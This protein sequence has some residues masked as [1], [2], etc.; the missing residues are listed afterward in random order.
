MS[1]PTESQRGK[2]TLWMTG[3]G[4]LA[5][6][7]IIL[8]VNYLTSLTTARLDMTE[9]DLHSLTDGTRNILSRI[10]KPVTIKLYI[11]PE[12]DLPAGIMPAILEAENLV[13]LFASEAPDG[14][15]KY[16]K[17]VTEPDTD[18]A[19]NATLAGVTPRQSG[20]NQFLFFGIVLTCEDRT[21][22][23]PWAPSSI[24]RQDPNS[25]D[26]LPSMLE[27]DIAKSLTEV[28]SRKKTKVGWM[29][30]LKLAG[31]AG[32]PMGGR[33]EEPW[34]LYN[35]LKQRF[36][37]VE[38]KTDAD[39]ISQDLNVLLLVHPAGF[40]ELT[41][42]AIDQYIL[43]GGNVVAFVDPKCLSVPPSGQPQF[44]GMPPQGGTPDNSNLDKLISSWGFTYDATQVVADRGTMNPPYQNP[45]A[46]AIGEKYLEGDNPATA[47]L[48][49]LEMFLPGGFTGSA[50]GHLSSLVLAKTS[51]TA[52]VG[53]AANF[54]P[55]R[56]GQQPSFKMTDTKQRSLAVR[57]TGKFKTAF[58]GGK[59]NPPPP[60]PEGGG[61]GGFPP[62]GFGPQG[63]QGEKG[64]EAPPANPAPAAPAAAPTPAPV[65][66]TATTPPVSA[67]PPVTA[68]TPPVSAATPPI[69][70]EP[71]KTPEGAPTPAVPPAAP[72][73]PAAPEPAPLLPP[74]SNP[75]PSPIPA[76]PAPG[77]PA[78]TPS[79]HITEG[80]KEASVY[81]VADVDMLSNQFAAQQIM[82][83]YWMMKNSN[84]A[85]ALNLVD[86]A[87]GDTDLL[88]VRSRAGNYR[89]FDKINQIREDARASTQSEMD[90]LQESIN[91]KQEELNK[92]AGDES[93]SQKSL[94]LAEK[95]KKEEA[96]K[97][98]AQFNKR[99]RELEKEEKAKVDGTYTFIRIMN[100]LPIP[101]CI[102][103]IGLAVFFIRRVRTAA[104]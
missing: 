31:G 61:P 89:P 57:L 45:A 56:Q 18:R 80:E 29:S 69:T 43:K 36:D 87:A 13:N 76:T 15:I 100:F 17:E 70:I 9:R 47:D 40:S 62:G 99:K 5:V 85:F 49:S 71:V 60:K 53:M 30:P 67:T 97:E 103:I 92:M 96:R 50:P 104:S 28:M 19:D 6:L 32:N 52:G 16:R 21:A 25:G 65:P 78:A 86:T 83:G 63:G 1:T 14:K 42:W 48:A 79:N 51:E 27:Y 12:K 94:T 90:K 55:E 64:P 37:L 41:Q 77:T 54:L 72:A 8:A 101:L 35:E 82:Q 93:T 58:P 102:V 39:T 66:A 20:P 44:P 11:S 95:K 84:I 38:V 81:L 7:G 73:T 22:V 26:R 24:F 91:K 10:E 46:L 2:S 4:A 3:L 74:A 23:I 88:K 33:G 75:P 68:T 59:P 34:L 98:M